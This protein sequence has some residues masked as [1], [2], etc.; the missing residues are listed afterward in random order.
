MVDGGTYLYSS[1][2]SAAR[3]AAKAINSVSFHT[4]Q[5]LLDMM[6]EGSE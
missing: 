1:E 4:A 5:G 3:A 6:F 2:R